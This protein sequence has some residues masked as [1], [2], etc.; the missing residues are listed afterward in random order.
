MKNKILIPLLITGALGAFF[1]FKYIGGEDSNDTQKR[2]LVL[3]TVMRTIKE[4]HFSPRQ[5]DDTFSSRVYD[6]MFDDLDYEKKF[7]TA[8]DMAVLSPYKYKIDDEINGNSLE[9][10]D[11]FCDIF[12]KNVSRAEGYYKDILAKPFTFDKKEELQL[13]GDKLE[14]A[15]D[16]NALK[17]RWRMYLKYRV[18]AK[19]VELKDAQAKDSTK[20]KVV[21]TD[22]QLE[23]SARE[24]VMKNQ[25]RFFKRLHKTDNKQ[26]FTVFV[27]NITA[28]ED[29]H[30]NYFPPK[31]KQRFDEQ[32]S[33]SFFGIGA[34]LREEDG[35]IKIVSIVTGSPCWKQGELKAGDEI[36]KVGQ[37]TQEPVDVQGYEIDDVVELIRGKKGTEVRLTVKK[38]DGSTKVIPIIRGEV[39]Y[40]ETFAKSAIIKG[41][42]GP[43]GYIYLPEFYSDFNHIN[44]RRCSEDVAIEVQKLKNAGVKGI[45]LDLRYNGGGSLSDVV[46]MAGLFIDQGP[47][48]QVK[49]SDAPAMKLKDDTKGSLYDG[50]LAIMVNEGSA[51]ASE[52]MAAAMQDYKRAVIVGSTTY[53]KGTVQKLVSLDEF[54]DPITRMRM[55]SNGDGQLGSLKLTV[56]KFYRVN[57]GS[58]QLKGVTPD[59]T[60]PDPYALLDK[61]ERG[62]K[63]ALQWDEIP[64][65]DYRATVPSV[66]GST[67]AA[68][69]QQRVASNPIFKMIEDNAAKMKQHQDDNTVLLTEADY[70]KELDESSATSKKLEEVQKKVNQLTITNPKEDMDKI[71]ADST[72]VAKNNDWL[73]N[74]KKDIYLS[75]TVNI[76]NDMSKQ[77]MKVNMGTGMK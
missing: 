27:N 20:D 32:M 43:V 59:V 65:A 68:L 35:K 55:Q 14:F 5:I 3:Q 6:K 21:K 54:L 72:S 39:L 40:E 52:I 53:G 24:S 8:R 25:D 29:P 18:L 47:V 69:S 67:L 37:G 31:E 70:R 50:P 63:S 58:T 66:N 49:S 74:L 46:D 2:E 15:A 44:G 33:G 77:S 19:Y 26:L 10:F 16:E 38:V 28:S 30:T 9:F 4:G 1:S 12:Q 51:S 22:A 7:F 17:D 45:I 56:Q 73:K 62:D 11:K 41:S 48:V 42:D 61:G 75:E 64:A 23:A 34:Q 36:K 71:N 76:I 57:G 13:N 60:L